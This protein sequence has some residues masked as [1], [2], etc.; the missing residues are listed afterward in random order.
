MFLLTLIMQTFGGISFGYFLSAAI[1]DGA[2]ALYFAPLFSMPLTL[3]SGMFV[4]ASSMPIYLEIFSYISPMKY[5]FENLAGLE[6]SNSP[7]T[8]EAEEF[9]KFMGIENDYW[10]GILYLG[11]LIF[12]F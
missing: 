4:N 1:T 8:E 6:L 2:T 3:V 5:A 7:Y 11:I 10:M 9:M 12:A